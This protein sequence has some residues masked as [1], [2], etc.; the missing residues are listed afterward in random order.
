MDQKKLLILSLV[1]GIGALIALIAL[2]I[3]TV[4][5]SGKL[6]SSNNKIV[7]NQ[8]FNLK[9]F[10]E[11]QSKTDIANVSLKQGPQGVQGRQGPAGP[12]G[13]NFSGVGPLMCV[14]QN[15]VATPTYGKGEPAIVYLDKKQ[16]TP[17]QYWF[18]ENNENG[19]V[20]IKN[21]FTGNCLT[22]N[23]L[24]DIFSD[25][26][27]NNGDQQFI[28]SPNMQ[29]SSVSQQNQC[30]SIENYERNTTNSNNSYNLSDLSVK[31]GSNSGNVQR[32]KLSPCSSSQNLNQTWFA[33]N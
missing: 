12:T 21:K 25:I 26:C 5:L 22:T 27:R 24:G 23:K 16:Y 17:V 29:L 28:W 18:L 7:E 3:V 30:V 20:T 4:I 8:D 19:T 10:N 31:R 6:E 15:K 1:L 32:L 13:G 2:I 14:G 11:I 9:Q 33:G